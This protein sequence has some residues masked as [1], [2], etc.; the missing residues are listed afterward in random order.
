MYAIETNRLSKAFHNIHA[1]QDLTLKVPE[2][3]IYGFIGENGSC[4]STT[5]KLI[6]GL[7]VPSDGEI[8]LYGRHYT[9]AIK[10]DTK[11]NFDATTTPDPGLVKV[12]E[13]KGFGNKVKAIGQIIKDGAREQIEINR[14][15][16]AYIQS[17]ESY[18]TLLEE[19]RVNRQ[20][21]IDGTRYGRK[22]KAT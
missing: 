10:A 14:E 4:K 11:A 1:V 17:Q 22:R 6:C 15:H 20:A 5:K 21:T 2:G 12:K 18:A 7:L 9:D 19:Q 16:R 13:A 8:R 3:S